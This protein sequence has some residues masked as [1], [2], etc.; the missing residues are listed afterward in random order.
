MVISRLSTALVVLASALTG[1]EQPRAADTVKSAALSGRVTFSG[2]A[3]AAEPIDVSSEPYC[4]EGSAGAPVHQR[5][6]VGA[7]NGLADVIV[8]VKG[9]AAG[10]AQPVP[11]EPAVLDQHGCMYRP[12]VLP[13]R[14]GQPLVVRNSDQVM[15]NVHATAKHNPSFN[16]GQPMAGL[17]A[18]RVMR[19]PELAI[20]V[21]C[22]IH[23]WMEASIAVFDHSFYA[24]T[25]SDGSFTIN[26]LPPGEYEIEAW[27]PTLG[28]Q[29]KR[30]KVAGGDVQADFQFGGT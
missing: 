11:K 29:I 23:D 17:E 12:S 24:V 4:R 21:R 15:H 1:A 5:V 27:H 3:P 22:D 16:I 19:A 6:R 9:V 20:P 10:A 8:H 30:V 13:V 14:V 25:S 28:V 7:Q 18:R 26:G 2:R